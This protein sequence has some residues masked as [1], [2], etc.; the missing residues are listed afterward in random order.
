MER[1]AVIGQQHELSRKATQTAAMEQEGAGR[2]EARQILRY[3][4]GLL[5]NSGS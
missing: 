3:L 4:C 2:A 5:F 1:V